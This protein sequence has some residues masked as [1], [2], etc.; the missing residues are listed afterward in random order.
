[1]VNAAA[2]QPEDT[3]GRGGDWKCE[4]GQKYNVSKNCA[5]SSA[6]EMFHVLASELTMVS[7]KEK[8]KHGYYEMTSE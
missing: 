8:E 4:T 7:F 5:K 6:S 2:A 3:T 1:M